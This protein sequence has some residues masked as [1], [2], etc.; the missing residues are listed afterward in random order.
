MLSVTDM[1][2]HIRTNTHD[3][4]ET[5]YSDDE[6]LV[7]IN[8]A[9]RFIRR[10]IL[11]INPILL[12]DVPIIGNL[13]ANQSSIELP[14]IVSK[15]LTVQCNNIELEVMDNTVMDNKTGR[16]ES[17]FL[18]GFKVINFYPVPDISVRYLIR[19]VSDLKLLSLADNSPFPTDFD[20][21][22]Y[23]YVTIRSSMV[24]EFDMSQESS[25]LSNIIAQLETTIRNI[26]N[27]SGISV[28]GYWDKSHHKY[29]RRY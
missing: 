21:F 16:P 24:N 20:D 27:T 25:L 22:I 26:S 3:I 15:I 8:D 28:D 11:D 18:S 10:T 19:V 6:L 1:I 17:Y 12:A 29:G 2:K 14:N 9:V 4:E 13:P 7:Y 23:E 5:G